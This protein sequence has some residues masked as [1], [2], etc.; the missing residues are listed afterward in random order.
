[1]LKVRILTVYLH[2]IAA[3]GFKTERGACLPLYVRHY[4]PKLVMTV[5]QIT[6]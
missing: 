4:L 2:L 6:L 3:T 5:I 1:M